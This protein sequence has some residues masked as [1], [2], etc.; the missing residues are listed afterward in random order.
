LS[1]HFH[2]SPGQSHRQRSRVSGRIDI[3][4]KVIAV[5]LERIPITVQIIIW[6]IGVAVFINSAVDQ[7][8]L[9]GVDGG[10][11]VVA[12]HLQLEAISVEVVVRGRVVA[13]IVDAVVDPF[14]ATRVD[15]RVKVVTVVSAFLREVCPDVAVPVL[16]Q[17]LPAQILVLAIGVKAGPKE[18][19]KQGRPRALR[20]P[21]SSAVGDVS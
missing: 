9:P 2:H 6:G 19:Q 21:S 3:C 5:F 20:A 8:G 17:Q 12:V 13:V 16:V 11:L 14:C 1:R 4:E 10:I 7:L 15:V 18:Q